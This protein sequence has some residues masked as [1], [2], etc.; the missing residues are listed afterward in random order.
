M[1]WKVIRQIAGTTV[2]GLLQVPAS[3]VAQTVSSPEGSS[4]TIIEAREAALDRSPAVAVAAAAVEEARGR[5]LAARTYPHN[6]EV[7]VEAAQ[8]SDTGPA[9]TDGLLAISQEIEIAGQ[10]GRRIE[11]ARA[12]LAAAEARL[13][14]RRLEVSTAVTQ[15]FANAVRAGEMRE[16]ASAEA[17]LTRELVEL[18][19]R[20]LEAGAGTQIQA[21]VARAAAG[22][23]ARRLKESEAEWVESMARLA[24]AAGLPAF[25][26]VVAALPRVVPA[27]PNASLAELIGRA[28]AERRDLAALRLD[29]EGAHRQVDLARALAVPNVRIGAFAEREEGEDI[30][31]ATVGIPIPLFHRNRGEIA[32]A[33]AAADRVEAELATAELAVAREVTTA[34][35]HYESAAAAAHDLER[36]VVGTLEE[37]LDLLRRALDAGKVGTSEVLLL[38]REL[39]EARREMVDAAAEALS[40]RAALELAVGRLLDEEGTR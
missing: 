25:G 27:P 29:L 23:A 35:A 14:R 15:A 10:R 2:L 13:G 30:V 1:S 33:E 6:P 16:L 19:E 12:A 21:N 5:L 38:R 26:G 31:G 8:R 18:E 20:R 3:A 24:E 17:A 37:S 32:E 36:L 34:L 22:R 40:A 28:L 4:L 39:F 7:E 9:G 11:A